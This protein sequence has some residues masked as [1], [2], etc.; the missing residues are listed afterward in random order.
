[1]QIIL[2]SNNIRPRFLRHHYNSHKLDI[3]YNNFDL[4]TVSLLE[5]KDKFIN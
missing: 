2:S 5:A 3:L 4:I 1:M